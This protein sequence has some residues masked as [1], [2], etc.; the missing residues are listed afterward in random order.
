MECPFKSPVKC[1]ARCAF[2]SIIGLIFSVLCLYNILSAPL[3]G[4]L[5]AKQGGIN[6]TTQP[7]LFFI[8][9][10]A[11]VIPLPIFLSFT[12][13]HFKTAIGAR[14]FDWIARRQK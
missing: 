8:F 7:I 9:Y 14:P 2:A 3:T 5:L 1:L 11:Y 10:F 4:H 13:L 12:W 6:F